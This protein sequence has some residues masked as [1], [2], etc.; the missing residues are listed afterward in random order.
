MAHKNLLSERFVR[1]E[2]IRL[3]NRYSGKCG[4]MKKVRFKNKKEAVEAG[5][6][7]EKVYGVKLFYFKCPICFTYHLTK[8]GKEGGNQN[9][10]ISN[11]HRGVG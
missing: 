1:E 10:E 2:I 8:Q 6:H 3:A 4:T 9:I 11:L 5:K 7:Q